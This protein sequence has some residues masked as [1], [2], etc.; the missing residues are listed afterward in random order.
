MPA[1][2]E[3]YRVQNV[4]EADEED[5][6][7][8]VVRALPVEATYINI[9]S[10]IGY[11]VMLAKKLAPTIRVHAVEPL[12]AFRKA[13]MENLRLNGFE[14]SDFTIHPLAVSSSDGT[15]VIVEKGFESRLLSQADQRS[16]CS[17]AAYWAREHVKGMLA[18][19]GSVRY[20]A[21]RGRPRQIETVSLDSLL[22]RVGSPVDL[23]SMDVQG[24]EVEILQGGESMLASGRIKTFIIGTHGR[25][26]HRRCLQLLGKHGYTIEYD[27]P[28]T[29]QQPDGIIIASIGVR[30][31]PEVGQR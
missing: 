21:G 2:R 13:F 27:E 14:E 10:A 31:L 7:T 1:Q 6:F 3:R 11:Y 8:T 9:G 18:R 29:R 23:L 17:R 25:S 19:L 20:A 28:D 5:L 22:A 30:R 4:H 15:Q 26:L 12:L 16:T 24:L